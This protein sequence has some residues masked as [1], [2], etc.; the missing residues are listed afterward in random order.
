MEVFLV[1]IE[2]KI[3]EELSFVFDPEFGVSIVDLGYIYQLSVDAEKNVMIKMTCISES[4]Q[5]QEWLKS[6]V[7]F[8]VATVDGVKSVTVKI[9]SEPKWSPKMMKKGLK[10]E[11]IGIKE[12]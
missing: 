2:D 6:G 12:K 11:L 7:E 10:K 4:A 1:N 8:A 9:V 5:I 3:Y